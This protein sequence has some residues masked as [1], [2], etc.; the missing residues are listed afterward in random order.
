[1]TKGVGKASTTRAVRGSA[2]DCTKAL[3]N[4]STKRPRKDA[5]RDQLRDQLRATLR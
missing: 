4:G 1:M 3:A 2:K 5:L